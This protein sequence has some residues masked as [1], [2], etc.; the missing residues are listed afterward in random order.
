M[1]EKSNRNLTFDAYTYGIE[2][3]GLRSK[4]DI[5]TVICYAVAKSKVKL[6]QKI[7]S[8]AMAEGGIAN[9]FEVADAF[10]RLFR[11]KIITEDENGCLS[12]SLQ[13]EK[14]IE[15]VEKDLPLSIREKS[16][17]IAMRLAEKEMY[18]KENKVDIEECDYGFNVTMHITDKDIDFMVLR[19]NV[20]TM[21]QAVLIKEKFI[22]NPV[23][24][25]N[26]LI[27]SL[28]YD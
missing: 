14:L 18:S 10:S 13:C 6:T 15:M 9:Y 1:N 21:E 8:D 24:I 2:P 27:H 16:I 25:Y 7:I 3:G 17:K 22:E 23:K 12:A 19:L 26:N 20:P 5:N 28:F 4:G 11:D